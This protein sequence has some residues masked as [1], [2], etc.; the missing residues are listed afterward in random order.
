MK[1]SVENI[2]TTHSSCPFESKLI[3]MFQENQ[4]L[5][6]RVK[7]AENLLSEKLYELDS[8][9]NILS[10]RKNSLEHNSIKLEQKRQKIKSLKKSLEERDSEISILNT[11]IKINKEK[12]NSI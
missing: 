9:V 4:L 7:T 2:C 10:E 1:D 6:Q 12:I 8:Q 5:Y 11:T 3:E